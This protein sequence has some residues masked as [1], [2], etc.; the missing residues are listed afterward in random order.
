[1]LKKTFKIDNSIYKS[2]IILK[3]IE[4]F[5]DYYIISFENNEIIID[6][7]DNIDEIFNEFMNYVIWLI[8]E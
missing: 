3:A 5:R 7:Y 2:N 1:M 4:D 8:N 6:W